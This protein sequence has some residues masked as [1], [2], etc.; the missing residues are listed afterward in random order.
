MSSIH[1]WGL[2]GSEPPSRHTQREVGEP[3]ECRAQKSSGALACHHGV[4]EC[5]ATTADTTRAV[6]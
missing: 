6:G 4:R 2:L 3:S 1:G 5:N